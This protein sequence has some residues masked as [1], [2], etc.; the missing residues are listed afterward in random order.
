VALVG[1]AKGARYAAL[2]GAAQG[3]GFADWFA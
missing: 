3:V 2:A 1:I